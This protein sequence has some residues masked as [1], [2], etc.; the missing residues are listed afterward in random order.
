MTPRQRKAKASSEGL[1]LRFGQNL[2][3]ARCAAGLSQ[4]LL[5]DLAA[6]HRTAVGQLERGERVARVDTLAKLCGAL[7]IEPGVLMEGIEW[8]PPPLVGTGSF[9]IEAGAGGHP[10]RP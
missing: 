4:E 3:R 6:I 5:G 7:G 10:P 9:D 8:K 2:S 1:A